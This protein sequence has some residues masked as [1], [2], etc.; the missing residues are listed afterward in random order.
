[1]IIKWRDEIVQV[2][3]GDMI[4]KWM[5]I[6]IVTMLIVTILHIQHIIYIYRYQHDR[7]SI[8]INS[9][10]GNLNIG[11]AK[12]NS[13][14][15]WHLKIG[16]ETKLDISRF[17]GALSA[18]ASRISPSPPSITPWKINMEPEVMMVCKLIFLFNWVIL[19]F[20]VNL[21]A[22]IFREKT[23]WN[24]GGSSIYHAWFV[25]VCWI[26]P[27]PQHDESAMMVLWG[28]P[29]YIY[30]ATLPIHMWVM[31]FPPV[32]WC[33]HPAVLCAEKSNQTA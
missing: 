26:I 5:T 13:S 21:P 18:M 25:G 24:F 29:V 10:K 15:S 17:T 2:V 23:C 22:R 31:R 19:W 14:Q 32:L 3:L 27:S 16:Q 1:M 7:R 8:D 20:H 33:P 9:K 11:I 30:I 6:I 12:E 28:I 4:L